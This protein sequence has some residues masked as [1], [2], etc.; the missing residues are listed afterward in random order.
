MPAPPAAQG[1]E[2]YPGMCQGMPG[3]APVAQMIQFPSVD[4]QQ[5]SGY[6]MP[7]WGE[8]MPAWG[9]TQQCPLPQQTQPL[10]PVAPQTLPTDPCMGMAG[11]ADENMIWQA[12][13]MPQQRLPGTPRGSNR[14]AEDTPSTP[15]NRVVRSNL[16]PNA[17]SPSWMRTPSPDQHHYPMSQFRTAEQRQETAPVVAQLPLPAVE[18][19]DPW[20]N[21]TLMVA[22][23]SYFAESEGYMSVAV[24]SQVRAMLDNPHCGDSKS[25][26]PAYVYCCQ[27]NGAGWVPQQL[28]WRCY[29]DESGRRW[30]CDDATGA[31]CWVDEM[32]KNA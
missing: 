17:A 20:V 4:Q 5:F 23:R 10:P 18:A 24:G 13:P 14:P 28:L 3:S 30:A 31:W 25:A 32:E 2:M 7:Y 15:L 1:W 22:T 12:P 29:V 9:S 6:A 21:T 16:S 8:P 26:F 11:V 27:G 19:A